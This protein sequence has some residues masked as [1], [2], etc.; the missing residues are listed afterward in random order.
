M[1]IPMM[2]LWWETTFKYS[3]ITC[4]YYE[5]ETFISKQKDLHGSLSYFHLN[6]RGLSTNWHSFRN[7]ICDLHGESFAFDILGITEIFKC[8]DDTR[9]SLPGYH[10]LIMRCRDDGARGGVGLFIRENINFIIREDIS[11]FTPHIFESIF[12]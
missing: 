5:T 11:V 12:I 7:L 10:P 4:N 6:C 1:K 3:N 2:I 9:L 8:V